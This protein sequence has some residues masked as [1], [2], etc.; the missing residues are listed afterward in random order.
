MLPV[1]IF[2]SIKTQQLHIVYFHRCNRYVS[3]LI[4]T[5]NFQLSI[6]NS[7]ETQQL[8]IVHFHRCN[9]YVSTL[10]FNFQLSIFN[11]LLYGIR[12]AMDLPNVTSS[13]YSKAS[14]TEI[15]LAIVLIV[16]LKSFKTLER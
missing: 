6:F 2:N 4:L 12:F 8:H 15:P 13:A 3:T 14:P 5:F 10:I 16:P 11:Y 1:F 9:R 7:I